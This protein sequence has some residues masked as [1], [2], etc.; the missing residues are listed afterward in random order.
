MMKHTILCVDDEVDNVEA[1]ERLFRKKYKVLKATSGPMALEILDQYP[2]EITVIL[3]DQRMPLMTGVQML[4]KAI[5]KHPNPIRLLLTGYTDLE[6]VIEAVN[7][8]Q[9][10]RYL[11]KPWDPVDLQQTVDLAVERFVLGQELKKKNTE[12]EKAL[13]ELRTLDLAKNQFMILINHELKT[14]LTSILNFLGLLKETTLD[15]DQNRYVLRIQKNSDRLKELIDDVLILMRAETGQTKV[16]KAD[17]RLAQ[18]IQDIPIT[19]QDSL[20]KKQQKLS[21]KLEVEHVESDY[22]VLK[23]VIHRLIHNASKFGSENSLIELKSIKVENGLL[24][25]IENRGSTFNMAKIEKLL[26]PFFLDENV[27]HHSTGTG[28]GL[29]ISQSLLKTLGTQLQLENI[30]NGARVSV[31]LPNLG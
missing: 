28:M 24:L 19:I 30:E 17:V 31:H 23:E 29:A 9:I 7:K 13:T 6:S 26:E 27:M 25:T 12:L 10:S 14:P 3:T 20:S 18:I 2:N 16:Q 21:L 1:L 11:T 8:G 5:E 4:E 15:E 22:F